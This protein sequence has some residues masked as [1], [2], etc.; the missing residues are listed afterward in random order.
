MASA[1]FHISTILRP[2]ILAFGAVLA[3][4][5]SITSV[6]REHDD[7]RYLERRYADVGKIL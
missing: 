7:E 3:A 2:S 6:V 5:L 4:L 1:A